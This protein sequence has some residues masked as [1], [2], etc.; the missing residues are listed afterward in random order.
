MTALLIH[1]LFGAELLKTTQPEGDHFYNRI[2]GHRY[3]FTDCQ[4]THPISYSDVVTTRVDAQ[5]G[6][7]GAELEVLRKAYCQHESTLE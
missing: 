7:T 4:F 2:G 5:L 1:D 3:D 6:A